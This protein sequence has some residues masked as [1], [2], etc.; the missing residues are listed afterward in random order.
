TIAPWPY[1]NTT[2]QK[3]L[4]FIDVMGGRNV[5]MGN[6]EY[7][8]LE[9][10]W[11][12]IDIARGQQSWNPVLAAETP[13]Y[14]QLTQGQIDKLAMKRGVRYFFAHPTVSL[15]RCVVKFFNFWQLER[16]IVAGASQ[17][18]FGQ[19]TRLQLIALALVICGSYATAILSGIFGLWMA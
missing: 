17:G 6:Y 19:F 1:R 18:L 11:A 9:R 14:S 3:T 10:S 12:T 5:M 8:P 16:T 13:G 15:Q 2:L 4:T 7:T